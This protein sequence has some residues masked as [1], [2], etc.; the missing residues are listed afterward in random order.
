MV[1]LSIAGMA[2]L[3]NCKEDQIRKQIDQLKPSEFSVHKETVNWVVK[4]I[5]L[6]ND[7]VVKEVWRKLFGRDVSEDYDLSEFNKKLKQGLDY[8]PTK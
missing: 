1:S 6:Y 7:W 4:E 8:K 2:E 5:V 3:Y